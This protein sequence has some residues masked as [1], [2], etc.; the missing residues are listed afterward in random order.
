MLPNGMSVDRVWQLQLMR[1]N[2]NDGTSVEERKIHLQQVV[3]LINDMPE[4]ESVTTLRNFPFRQNYRSYGG[5]EEVHYMIEE[6][7]ETYLQA[8]GLELVKGRWF[9]REEVENKRDV[10]VIA[11]KVRLTIF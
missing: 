6:A 5:L 9:S 3:Q 7:T 10:V 1:R 2:N 4:V 11:D 8:M